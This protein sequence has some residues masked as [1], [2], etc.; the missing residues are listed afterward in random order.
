MHYNLN[1]L[2]IPQ[3]LI[4]CSRL[5]VLA[6]TLQRIGGGIYSPRHGA[7]VEML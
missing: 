6:G 1:I 2:E 7:Q 4:K 3:T 5:R